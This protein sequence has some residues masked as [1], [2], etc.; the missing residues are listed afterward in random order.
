MTDRA[1]CVDVAVVEQRS[2]RPAPLKLGDT[3]AQPGRVHGLLLVPLDRLTAQLETHLTGLRTGEPGQINNTPAMLGDA[4]HRPGDGGGLGD[5]T[6][7][8][9]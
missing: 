7:T 2:G 8:D 3:P 4:P 9:K 5:T 1:S 6:G